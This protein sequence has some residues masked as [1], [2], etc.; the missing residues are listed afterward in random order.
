MLRPLLQSIVNAADRFLVFLV[1]R[2]R[3]RETESRVLVER[4]VTQKLFS[5][6]VHAKPN[7]CYVTSAQTFTTVR[8]EC[9]AKKNAL[10]MS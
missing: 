7:R 9:S 6:G 4:S 3:S 8:P 2:G 10:L 1:E 5:V